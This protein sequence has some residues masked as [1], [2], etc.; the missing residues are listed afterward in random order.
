MNVRVCAQDIATKALEYRNDSD[1]VGLGKVCSC[2]PC[3]TFSDCSQMATPSNAKVQKTAKF[4]VF[5][6]TGRKNKLIETKFGTQAYT[7]GLL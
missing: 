1:A 7:N 2:V 5:A 3:S 6:A 4:G